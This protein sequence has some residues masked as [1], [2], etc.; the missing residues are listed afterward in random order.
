[1]L[2]EEGITQ[3]GF[4]LG[5]FLWGFF[6]TLREEYPSSPFR[7]RAQIG[8]SGNAARSRWIELAVFCYGGLERFGGGDSDSS[9]GGRADSDSRSLKRRDPGG[10]DVGSKRLRAGGSP[11]GRRV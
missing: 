6:C 3:R 2:R 5:V 1:V 10:D 8:R 9:F 7:H 11:R 4:F